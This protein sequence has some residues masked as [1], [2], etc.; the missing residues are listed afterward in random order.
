AMPG[1]TRASVLSCLAITRGRSSDSST[2]M[3]IAGTA[4]PSTG[5]SVPMPVATRAIAAVISTPGSTSM[6]RWPRRVGRVWTGDSCTHPAFR[7]AGSVGSGRAAWSQRR[8]DVRGRRYRRGMRES[9]A[10]AGLDEAQLQAVEHGDGPLVIAAG[11]GTGKT[12]VLTSR[13]ARLLE[14]GVAP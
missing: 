12:R 3:T 8:R 5:T 7:I 6:P 11:A 13:V 9:D 10:L 14:A 2:P 1:C 4:E